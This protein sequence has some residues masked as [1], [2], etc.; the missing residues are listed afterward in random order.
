[1]HHPHAVCELCNVCKKGLL[2]NALGLALRIPS[3]RG[4]LLMWELC[5]MAAGV[6][7]LDPWELIPMEAGIVKT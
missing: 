3:V 7:L 1:M 5:P 6:T 4:I 2:C